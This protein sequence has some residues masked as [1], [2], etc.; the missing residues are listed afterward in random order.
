[1]RGVFPSLYAV[2]LRDGVFNSAGFQ[3]FVEFLVI[4]LNQH[5]ASVLCAEDG[6]GNFAFRQAVNDRLNFR[7][8]CDNSVFTSFPRWGFIRIIPGGIAYA[9]LKGVMSMQEQIPTQPVQQMCQS[10]F[11]SGLTTTTRSQFTR[12]WIELIN[13]LEKNKMV[14]SEN[15]Q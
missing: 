6:P 2:D 7:R 4:V 15:K 12:K 8:Y 1:M 9:F 3:G 10:V 5:L 13:L 14:S 11:K